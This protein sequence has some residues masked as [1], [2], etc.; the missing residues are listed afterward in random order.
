[1]PLFILLLLSLISFSTPEKADPPL[2]NILWITSEDNGPFLGC[3]GDAFATTPNLDRM[4]ANGFRYTHAYANA[5]V[6]SPTRNTIITGVYASAAGNQNMRSIYD[7]SD[8]IRLFPEYLREAG[9]YCTNNVKEDYN[10]N[11]AQSEGTWDESS[12]TA[13]YRDRKPGQPFFAVFNSMITHE[14]S[15]YP[16]KPTEK[17]RH[18]P[19]KVTLP[20][21]HPDT[22]ELRH[23]WAQ[24]YDNVEDMDAWV[25]ELLAELEASGEAENTIVFYYSD[26]GGVLPRS[27]RFLYDSGTHVP[28]ILHIPQKYKQLWPA[29]KPGSSVDR[30]VSFVDLAPTLLSIIG[31]SIPGYIQGLAFLG[32]QKT[33]EPTYV[34]MFRDRMDERYDISRA[35]RDKKYRYVRNYTPDRPNGQYLETLWM[36]RGT[37]SWE[38]ACRAGNCNAVQQ[39]FWLPKPAEELYDSENDPWEVSNLADQPKYSPVLEKMRR[40]NRDWIL[41]IK[42]TGLIQEPELVTRTRNQ[43]AYD[44]MRSGSANLKAILAAA[45]LASTATTTDLPQLQKLLR[46]EDAAIRYWGAKSLSMLG[47]GAK[48]ALPGLQNAARDESLSVAVGAAEVLYHLGDK[49]TAGTVLVRALQSPDEAARNF[50]LNVIDNLDDDQPPVRKAVVAMV[51]KAE[52]LDRSHY[53]IRVAKHLFEEWKMNPAEMGIKFG[54]E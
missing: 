30:L 1:M 31:K 7:K 27:K 18:D 23:D 29:E 9:Y 41:K 14:S 20:P 12:K 2:P 54:W 36:Q 40:A 25:G 51:K 19:A 39:A 8:I 5:P 10:M 43:S 15:V 24:Y 11:S 32:K 37:R 50:G 13:H 45:E 21:Y 47:Q 44:Y 26:H 4:A 49:E 17:L 48:P 16:F 52:S 22:P 35:V 28:F 53:D 46:S 33:R 42:D 3:Y 34:Y 38:A 6:C